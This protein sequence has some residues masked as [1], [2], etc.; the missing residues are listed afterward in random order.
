[1]HGMREKVSPVRNLPILTNQMLSR[2]YS[3][4]LAG[5]EAK[6][7]EAEVNTSYGLRH[8]EIVGL[9]DKAVEESK[10]RVSAAI[11]SSGFQSPHH[12]PIRVLVSLAPADLKKEGSIYDLAI[13]LGFLLAER[14]INFNP[15]DK[16]ILGEL[17]LD[18]RLRPVK[19]AISFALA[20]KEKGFSELILPKQNAPEAGLIKGLKT[21]G[22]TTLGEAIDYLEGKKEILSSK[23]NIEDFLQT[24]DY[25]VNLNQIK[26]QESAKR[27]LE[28]SAAGGHNLLMQGPP[29]SGKTLLARALPSIL[30]PLSFEE[31]LEVTR[32]Y[33]IAGLLPPG[34][35]LMNI[36]PFRSPHHTSS[37]VALIGGGNPP[38]PGEITLAHRGVLFL[39]ELPEFHRDVLESLRQPIEEG[40]IAV[41]RAKH[42]LLMPARFTL[43]AACNPCP[44]G[45]FGSPEK[46][47]SCANSQIKMYQRKL[48]GPLMD[49]ID[50]FINVP[51]LKYEKLAGSEN[52]NLTSQTKERV[53]LARQIQFARF[54]NSRSNAEMEIPQIK[55]YCPVDSK[56]ETLLKNYVDSG[57]LSGRGYHRVLKTARTIADLDNS[58]NILYDHLAEALM[59]RIRED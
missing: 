48:S 56:S 6:T 24:P 1:M 11:E 33:S 47:C 13:A 7:I 2:V 36:R 49:R 53:R 18:G 30:P 4:A 57:K 39:D 45:N 29:G 40:K 22:V 31:S 27:A 10:E 43:A 21:I 54:G 52:E 8:F 37:E 41:L 59:Y 19:G 46:K 14:K 28:I 34:K 38:R 5:I 51:A 50:I 35:P 3:A 42:S 26:G 32:I 16:I 9:P 17:A 25:P 44:C 20:A 23:I 55:K 15:A 12:Q 58:E